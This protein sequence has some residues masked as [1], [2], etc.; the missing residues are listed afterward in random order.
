MHRQVLVPVADPAAQVAVLRREI[1]EAVGR[2]IRKGHYVLGPELETL[3]T[4]FAEFIGT[5]YAVGVANGTDGLAI[6]LRALGIGRGDEVITVSHTAVATVAAIE[7]SGATPVL[8]DVERRF[9][10]LNPAHLSEALS[11]RTRAVVPVHLY[12]QS[13]DMDSI[14]SFCAVNGLALIED[15]SQAHGA[16]WRGSRLGSLGHVG[17]FSCYPTKNL[18]AL[19][20]AGI[21]VTSDASVAERIRRLRQYGWRRR[22]FSVEPGFNS[23]LDEIQAAVLRVKLRHLDA[24]NSRRA[25][26]A[27]SYGLAFDHLPISLPAFRPESTHVFHLYVAQV[28]DRPRFQGRLIENGVQTAIHY[29]TPVHLQTAYQERIK[30]QASLHFTE[31]LSARVVSLPM[32]PE[33]TPSNVD[34]VCSAVIKALE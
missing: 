11:A 15:V 14:Q 13:A 29:P 17:V 30:I 1:D 27:A 9:L 5:A 8:V 32:F 12:G 33:M 25:A 28:N 34:L 16:T 6:A 3:E 4:E 26:I 19:G 24:N 10:T 31:E 20:D 21:V 2:V 18:G 22:N 7:Q 23:R